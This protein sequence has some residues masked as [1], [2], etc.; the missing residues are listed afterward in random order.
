MSMDMETQFYVVRQEAAEKAHA[1]L[2]A[3]D[4]QYVVRGKLLDLSV[5]GALAVVPLDEMSPHEGDTLIFHFTPAQIREDLVAAVVRTVTVEGN[6]LEVHL[7]FAGLKE[8]DRLKL[9]KY[10]TNLAEQVAP[11][12][13]AP[14]SPATQ[15]T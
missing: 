7:Q 5:G 1:L 2:R 13:S 8:L 9:N 10:L 6:L 12:P 3:R 11:P 4:S 14:G 15:P